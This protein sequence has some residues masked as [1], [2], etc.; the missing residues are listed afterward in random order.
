MKKIYLIGMMGAG[1]TETGRALAREAGLDFVDLDEE[2]VKRT[3]M[4][5]NEIFECRGEPFF[6]KAER[7][8]LEEASRSKNGVI[9]TGGGAVLDPENVLLMRSSGKVV[10]LRTS[11][12][13]LWQ[14]TRTKTDRPLL[15]ASNPEEVLAKLFAQRKGVYESVHDFAVNTDGKTPGAVAEDIVKL[16]GLGSHERA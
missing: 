11:L 6:R 1:K 4:T 12:A 10:Y 5:I 9:A 8:A 7:D 3:H 13:T 2:I 14:R 15:R 16:L